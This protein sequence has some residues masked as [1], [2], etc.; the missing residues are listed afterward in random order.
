[1]TAAACLPRPMENPR[2]TWREALRFWLKLGFIS[3]GGPA[4]QI[5]VMHRELVEK[6]RWIDAPHFLHALNFCMLLPGPE[7]TQLATYCGWLLHGVRGGLAAGLLF[8]LPGAFA[9]GLLSWL[10]VTYG[11]VAAAGAVFHGLK[12]AV[13]AIVAAAVLHLGRKALTSPAAWLLAALAFVAL[14]FLGLP[15]PLV[16]LSALIAGFAAGRWSPGLL[17]VQG[18]KANPAAGVPVSGRRTLKWTAAGLVVWLL[19]VV[20][21][22]LWQGWEGTLAQLGWFFSKAAVVTFGGAYAVL[23]YV[24]QQ[25]VEHYQW[26]APGQ[27]LDGLALAETTPG[28]LIIVLQFVGFLAAWQHP[29]ELAPFTAALLGAGLTTWVTFVPTYLFILIGAPYVE[30]VRSNVQLGAALA[31]VTA[32][33][34]GVILN[35]AVWFA[36]Q[37]IWPGHGAVDWFAAVVCVTA[38]VALQWMRVGMIPVIA[39]CGLLGWAWSLIGM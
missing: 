6:K 31:A 36:W 20:M 9:L 38:F 29:G 26:I 25:A 14:F 8:V 18:G 17:K 39:V 35:L 32:A 10:Y 3:F 34:V 4:G 15:F 27:M 28:P 23:P 22:G 7:A 1:M 12:A 11:H 16:V 5:A 13:L 2:P 19:P 37:V 24:G 30:R 33:V 21:M